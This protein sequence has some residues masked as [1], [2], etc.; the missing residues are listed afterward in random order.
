MAAKDYGLAT[1]SVAG[2]EG[3][4]EFNC[5]FTVGKVNC[6]RASPDALIVVEIFNDE[7]S[8]GLSVFARV[9]SERRSVCFDIPRSGECTDE[10]FFKSI[11]VAR[12]RGSEFEKVFKRLV[13]GCAEIEMDGLASGSVA[14]ENGIVIVSSAA[15]EGAK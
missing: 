5:G 6:S 4:R 3:E 11:V 1:S 8:E 9:R 10:C 14:F 2:V 13:C 15:F 7:S 12:A